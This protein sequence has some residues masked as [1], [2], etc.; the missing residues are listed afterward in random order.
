MGESGSDDTLSRSTIASVINSLAW[1][2]TILVIFLVIVFFSNSIVTGLDRLAEHYRIIDASAGPSGF[3]FHA[4]AKEIEKGIASAF[5]SR[6]SGEITPEQALQAQKLGQTAAHEFSTIDAL[7]PEKRLRVLWVDDQPGNNV[8]LQYAFQAL[9]IIVICV[10][11]TDRIVQAFNSTGGF[12]VVITDMFRDAVRR[13]PDQQDGGLKTVETIK[14][15]FG[16][17]PVIIYAGSYSAEHAT[18]NLA[19][20]IIAITNDPQTVFTTVVQMAKQKFAD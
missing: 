11:D 4:E 16:N 5:A 9:G 10:E 19:K 12:D 20:P 3:S 7:H 14:N 17:V 15:N 1:P 6:Q 8:G 2:G 13:K 18:D